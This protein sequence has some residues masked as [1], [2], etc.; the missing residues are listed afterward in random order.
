MSEELRNCHSD[1]RL[2]LSV[3]TLLQLRYML[4]FAV[5]FARLIEGENSTLFKTANYWLSQLDDVYSSFEK[6]FNGDNCVV[7]VLHTYFD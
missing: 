1:V 4:T 2:H 3:H 6:S 5:K 7:C